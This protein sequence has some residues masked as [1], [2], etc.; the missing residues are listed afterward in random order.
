MNR[1][2]LSCNYCERVMAV[3]LEEGTTIEEVAQSACPL[4]N[5]KELRIMG[6]VEKSNIVREGKK[7]ACDARCT[8]ARGPLCDCLCLGPNHGTGK[9]VSYDK[10]YCKLSV[11]EKALLNNNEQYLAR[12]RRMAAAKI[13]IKRNV[14]AFLEWKFGES[15]RK[16][17][18]EW[19]GYG[20]KEHQ[21]YRTYYEFQKKI[22][23]I[24][25]YKSV[26][27]KINS[28]VKLIP[29]IG[30]NLDYIESIGLAKGLVK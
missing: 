29:Q 7:A 21:D 16:A 23:K 13:E 3:N 15:I 5:E 17:K 22:A 4:C 8:N 25:D 2:F 9:L 14:L 28:L 26:Q 24:E 19:F 1:Y 11:V 18:T 30:N 10:V 6:R 12:L 20:S 27:R